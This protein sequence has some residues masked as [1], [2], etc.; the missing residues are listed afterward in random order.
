LVQ[1]VDKPKT[2][3]VK[4][5]QIALYVQAKLMQCHIFSKNTKSKVGQKC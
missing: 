3:Q 2:E 4:K 1:K 5:T